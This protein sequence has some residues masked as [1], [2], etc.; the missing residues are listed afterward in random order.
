MK[1]QGW[2]RRIIKDGFRVGFIRAE[3]VD[4]MKAQGQIRDLIEI[5]ECQV[6]FINT[7][8]VEDI[9]FSAKHSKFSNTSF[10]KLKVGDKVNIEYVNTPRGFFAERLQPIIHAEAQT[11]KA[12]PDETV[13][14]GLL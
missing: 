7:K 11:A 8:D 5:E 2:V 4:N 10:D 1:A 6:G 13:H 14:M 3:G 12:E 9:F